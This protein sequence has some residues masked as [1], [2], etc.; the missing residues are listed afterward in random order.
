MFVITLVSD[1]CLSIPFKY[2]YPCSPPPRPIE[3]MVVCGCCYVYEKDPMLDDKKKAQCWAWWFAGFGVGP[4]T[5]PVSA[6]AR[7]P[8]SAPD[9]AS[10]AQLTL[11]PLLRPLNAEKTREDPKSARGR[12]SR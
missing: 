6:A 1:P 5:R 11:I 8:L 9:L 2:S 3:F 4:D 7:S 10:R 12:A